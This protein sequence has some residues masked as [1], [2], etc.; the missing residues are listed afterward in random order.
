MDG[1]SGSISY[2]E[3]Y[4]RYIAPRLRAID[5]LLKS[6]ARKISLGRAAALLDLPEG[7][8]RAFMAREHLRRLDGGA[9]LRLMGAGSSALCGLY[10]R[11]VECASPYVYSRDQV[12]YIYGLKPALVH[13]ICDALRIKEVTAFTLPEILGRCVF[14][15]KST[16]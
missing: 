2:L 13:S 7:E 4:S 14:D 6:R 3:A 8:V 12:A 5:L 1:L 16:G 9:L 10:R 11:E 15:V